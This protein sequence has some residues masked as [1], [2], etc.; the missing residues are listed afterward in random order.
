MSS[1]SETQLTNEIA[2]D[3]AARDRLE[4]QFPLAASL[5]AV[6]WEALSRQLDPDERRKIEDLILA[7]P[8]GRHPSDE[9]ARRTVEVAG[10][11]GL[12]NDV[13]LG[14]VAKRLEALL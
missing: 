2:V 5:R 7:T 11:A 13:I 12:A 4:R 14:I 10:A 6:Q 3:V 1:R 9:I 8:D